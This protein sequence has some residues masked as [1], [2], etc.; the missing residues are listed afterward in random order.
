MKKTFSRTYLQTQ[1]V[2]PNS[3]WRARLK[4]DFKIDCHLRK[5]SIVYVAK[6]NNFIFFSNLRNRRKGKSAMWE[7]VR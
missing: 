3:E 4:K 5:K 1:F 2:E 6:Q 7:T